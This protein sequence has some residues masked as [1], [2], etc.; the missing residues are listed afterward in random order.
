VQ[1]GESKE[2]PDSGQPRV[3]GAQ[4]IV[5]RRFEAVQEIGDERDVEISDT[6]IGG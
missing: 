3:A 4:G 5:P 1:R 6:E 2:R